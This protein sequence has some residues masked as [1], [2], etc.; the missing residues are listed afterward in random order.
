MYTG[1]VADITDT[2]PALISNIRM[3]YTIARYYSTPEHMT[4]LFT[5]LTNQMIRKCKDQITYPGKLWDQDK[6]TLIANMQA[7]V[8]LAKVYKEHYKSAKEQL[9]SQ[10]KSK[11]FDFDEQ[12]SS[13]GS[14]WGPGCI[15]QPNAGNQG[16]VDC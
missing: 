6:P 14:S 5:K 15:M 1:T 16:T 8:N 11:Q 2:V 7:S 12:V 4:R 10:P 13:L 3:M 9:A